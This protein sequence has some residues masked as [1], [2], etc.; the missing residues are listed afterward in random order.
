M[1]TFALAFVLTYYTDPSCLV[2]HQ[3]TLEKS[4]LGVV[5]E[6]PLDEV[7]N[8]TMVALPARCDGVNYK[9]YGGSDPTTVH[10]LSSTGDSFLLY[11]D[12][13]YFEVNQSSGCTL[14]D[15]SLIYQPYT[16]TPLTTNFYV[17]AHF[18]EDFTPCSSLLTTSPAP[19]L[20]VTTKGPASSSSTTDSTDS[21]DNR[22][23]EMY[24]GFYS[25]F[26]VVF[27]ILTGSMQWSG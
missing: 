6:S 2:Y 21:D 11:F 4:T 14:V 15:G 25:I 8:Q 7:I 13:A 24:V 16:I 22:I 17:K 20:E 1:T 9:V 27:V 5:V 12:G 23:I 3:D 18:Q 10:S 19:N 26:V